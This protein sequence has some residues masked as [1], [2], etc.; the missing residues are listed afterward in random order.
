MA[1][2]FGAIGT[3]VLVLCVNGALIMA[4]LTMAAMAADAGASSP[5]Y[6]ADNQSALCQAGACNAAGVPTGLQQ[7]WQSNLPAAASGTTPTG[8][9][10]FTDLWNT[11]FGWIIGPG[12]FI[13]GIVAA[14]VAFLWSVG[15]TGPVL[16]SFAL[17]VG[18]IWEAFSILVI[19]NFIRGT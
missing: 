14:P 7:G 19:I 5:G 1:E 3:L 16:G 10:T 12:K 18:V 8:S 9:G 11:L 4:N 6:Y 13:M 17:V 15:L 2:L